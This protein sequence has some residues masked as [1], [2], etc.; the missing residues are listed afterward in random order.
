M[1]VG[2]RLLQGGG[3][4]NTTVWRIEVGYVTSGW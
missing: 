2:S 1:V 3:T 4:S